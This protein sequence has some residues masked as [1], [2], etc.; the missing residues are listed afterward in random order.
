MPGITG[1]V[2]KSPPA[3]NRD[4]LDR[5]VR[6]MLHEK[7][8]AHGTY[9][10]VDL[11]L[12]V[13][14]VDHGDLC[15]DTNPTWNDR[16]TACLIFSGETFHNHL[17]RTVDL[18]G[19]SALIR[20]YDHCGR[21]FLE[22]LNGFYHGVLV[23]EAKGSAFLFNDRYGMRR[24]Y[25]HQ[26][27]DALYFASEA[28][29]LLA[30]KPRLREVNYPHLGQLFSMGCVLGNHSIFSGIDT[31]PMA[32]RWEFSDGRVVGKTQYFTP[33]EWERQDALK[34][35]DFYRELKDTFTRILPRY[36]EAGAPVGLSLTGGLDTRMIMAHSPLNSG[37]LPCYTFGST[38]RDTFDV[39]VAREVAGTCN[40]QHTTITVGDD[41]LSRFP[42]LAEKAVHITDGNLDASSGAAELYINRRARQIA[43]I[44]ITGNYGSEVLRSII[45]FKPKPPKHEVFHPD[46]TAHLQ[47]AAQVYRDHLAGNRSTFIVFKQAPWYN[48]NRLSLEQSQLINRTPFMDKELVEL[49]Y[50]APLEVIQSDQVSLRLVKS[51]SDALHNIITNRGAGGG[52]YRL[53]SRLRQTYHEMF[54][55]AEIGYDYDMPQWLCRLDHILR[56]LHVE[57]LFFGRHSFLHFRLWFREALAG[58]LKDLLL[59]EK[60]LRRPYI[61][62]SFVSQMVMDHIRGTGNYTNEIGR[63]I[64]LELIHRL[65][66]D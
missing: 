49:V 60:T 27:N 20:L 10:N 37:E 53:F 50:R 39:R 38:Y 19:N 24:I 6:S 44:R 18:R 36:F 59:D 55:M 65:F 8:Y 32:A 4:V 33:D 61:N 3:E 9:V 7:S 56:P 21:R 45:A 51:G 40:Q 52:S 57:N 17:G 41:F 35:E 63:L 25:F 22:H 62:R 43:P 34:P 23:D 16:N 30:A 66:V 28:K 54:H 42:E 15:P 48:Y 12:Y 5:M 58:Y 47:Q 14:W 13:G 26:E 11:G 29:A 2:S 46:F 31:L 64:T 1:I